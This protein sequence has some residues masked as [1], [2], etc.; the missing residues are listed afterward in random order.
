M[1]LKIEATNYDECATAAHQ[2]SLDHAGR[3]I[4][5]SVT[6]SDAYLLIA[7]RLDPQAPS[8]LGMNPPSC[9]GYWLNG[10]FKTF[11]DAQRIADQKC[12]HLGR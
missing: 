5:V 2:A 12:G 7:K 11:T 8:D 6:F 4:T 3:Y 9:Q 1:R 10:K